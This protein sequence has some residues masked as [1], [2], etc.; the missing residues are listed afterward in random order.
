MPGGQQQTQT[1]DTGDATPMQQLQTD[2]RS[3]ADAAA[4]TPNAMYVS[5][6]DAT[7][8]Q[9]SQT[10]WRSL[11]DAGAS[12]PNA[13]YVSRADAANDAEANQKTKCRGL[14]RKILQITGIALSVVVC[15]LLPYL[16]V[17]VRTQSYESARH[18]LEMGNRLKMAELRVTE[19]ER[20]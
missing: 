7:P 8:M 9:Q 12:T 4:N 10:D 1:G 6:A 3:L 13:M 17:E 14:G 16:A 19:L 18:Y 20:E 2:W 15:V 5:R 11:A